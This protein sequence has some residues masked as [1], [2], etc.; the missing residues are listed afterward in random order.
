MEDCG[1]DW[2]ITWRE[3]ASCLAVPSGADDALLLAPLIRIPSNATAVNTHAPK[4]VQW[5][6]RW[7][8]LVDQGGGSRETQ[9]AVMRATSPKYVP[10]EWMLKEAY[11]K[12][13]QGDFSSVQ[14]LFEVF[15]NPYAEQ[16]TYEK[17]YY[18]SKPKVKIS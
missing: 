9:S 11:D 13:A 2:T 10:R 4:W 16:E 6:R 7:I 15:K 5:I 12:A 18:V 3:L 14:E 1:S 8:A 17:K